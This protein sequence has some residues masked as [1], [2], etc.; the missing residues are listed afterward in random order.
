MA[1]GDKTVAGKPTVSAGSDAA[2][3]TNASSDDSGAEKSTAPAA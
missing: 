2:T 3:A 1:T